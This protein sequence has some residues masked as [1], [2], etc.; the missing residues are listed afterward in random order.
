MRYPRGMTSSKTDQSQIYPWKT[1][2]SAIALDEKWFPVRKDTVQ[3]PSGKIVNDF[4]VWE[5]PHIVVAV[6]L[7]KNGEFVLVQQ[8]RHGI[9]SIDY[10]F[11]AGAQSKRDIDSEA[12]ARRELEEE[13]GYI[14]GDWTH[15]CQVSLF[16]HKMTDLEDLYLA[17]DV[18]PE[19]IRLDDEDEP[20]RVV[21]K[22]PAELREMIANND[23][24]SAASLAAAM[25]VL[26]KLNL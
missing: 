22:T 14:G 12:A 8:Y 26:D 24:K 21:T 20:I 1:L 13:T 15:L 16:G 9:N 23:I 17:K 19:G 25:L 11:P 3:L 4:F 6:P 10:Q 18:V 5:S 2:S 7:T